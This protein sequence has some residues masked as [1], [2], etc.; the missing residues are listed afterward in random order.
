[1]QKLF[2]LLTL[3]ALVAIGCSKKTIVLPDHLARI[4]ELERRADLNDQLDS[5]RDI[6]IA[7]NTA[8]ITLLQQQLNALELELKQLIEEEQAARIAGDEAL[9]DSLASSIVLQ[10]AINAF[11]QFQI[12]S[13]NTKANLAL[14]RISTLK[15]R[16]DNLENDIQD[17]QTQVADLQ[18]EVSSLEDRM[19]LVEAAVNFNSNLISNLQLQLNALGLAQFFI[20]LSFQTQ[21]NNLKSRMSDVEGDITQIFN[22]LSSLGEE[23]TSLTSLVNQNYLDIQD[24]KDDLSNLGQT[25]TKVIDPCGPMSNQ[26]PNNPDEVLL[27]TSEGSLLAWYLNL[28]LVELLDGKYATTDSQ[29][30]HFDVISG[31]VV[32]R[33]IPTNKSGVRAYS[34]PLT[35]SE[36]SNG[37]QLTCIADESVL[38]NASK[39]RIRTSVTQNVKVKQTNSNEITMLVE[40]GRETL[41]TFDSRNTVI[42]TPQSVGTQQTKAC[43]N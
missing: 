12:A 21:I 14:S 16:V 30:C 34:R 4:V 11:V 28:G 7:A 3:V 35:G 20:N 1:M 22:D 40:A 17:L 37:I 5:M 39:V 19:F 23:L 9:A 6:A 31:N 25:I 13:I 33:G 43:N 26:S 29:S 42:A 36:P 41:V 18:H 32:E 24:L 2:T 15:V 10:S 38:L 8:S 27:Q